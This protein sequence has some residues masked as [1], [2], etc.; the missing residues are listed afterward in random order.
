MNAIELLQEVSARGVVIEPSGGRLRVDAPRG[1]ITPELR[2]ALTSQ[3]EELLRV[4]STT[5]VETVPC[6]GD[7][8]NERLVLVD[9]VGYCKHYQMSVRFVGEI[10]F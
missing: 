6:P 4:L 8:C 5:L 9:G 3:K 1:V 2:E 7:E 10:P